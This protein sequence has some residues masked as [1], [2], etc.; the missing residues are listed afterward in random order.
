LHSCIYI[1]QPKA[2][3]VIN[4]EVVG[5]LSV[6]RTFDDPADVGDYVTE[7][8]QEI[9]ILVKLKFNLYRFSVAT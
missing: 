2:V 9:P 8:I 1:H 3:N 4:D 5:D 6:G 7:K